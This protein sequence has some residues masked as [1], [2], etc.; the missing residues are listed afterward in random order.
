[1]LDWID[2]KFPDLATYAQ[3]GRGEAFTVTLRKE[4]GQSGRAPLTD[5]IDV[6]MGSHT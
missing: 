5:G 3:K 2:F 1:M 4:W 6:P